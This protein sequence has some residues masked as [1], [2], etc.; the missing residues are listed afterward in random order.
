MIH[1]VTIP[2][3]TPVVGIALGNEP[4]PAPTEK[5]EGVRRPT[6]ET[7]R[8]KPEDSPAGDP[9]PATG[10]PG[11]PAIAEQ[12]RQQVEAV[13][14]GLREAARQL[15]QQRQEYLQQ[16]QQA[17]VELALAIAAH[18]IHA[19]IDTGRF[20]VEELVRKMI[21]QSGK[22]HPPTVRLHPDDLSLLRRRLNDAQVLIED[23]CGTGPI[24]LAVDTSLERGSCR[25]ET[26]NFIL[27]SQLS[28]QLS[29]IRTR[30]LQGVAAADSHPG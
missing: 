21:A 19:Q 7:S 12:Q 22:N 2:L 30:L 20:A 29:D 28:D 1:E 8:T 11:Q 4:T 16:A 24:R 13:L 23:L 26:E 3:T 9:P 10:D 18:P 14:A 25:V 6:S 5:G 17:T 27:L 15:Q